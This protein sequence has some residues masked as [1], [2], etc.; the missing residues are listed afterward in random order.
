MMDKYKETPAPL[1]SA[2]PGFVHYDPDA[3]QGPSAPLDADRPVRLD[4]KGQTG[5]K[6]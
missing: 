5:K 1:P 6:K 3:D 4:G 2:P